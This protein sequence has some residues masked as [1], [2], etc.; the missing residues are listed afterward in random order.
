VESGARNVDHILTMQVLPQIAVDVLSK[1]A[2]GGGVK[3]VELSV[4]EGG[5]I[6]HEIR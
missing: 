4:G 6:R 5:A 3:S 2:E 1:Q